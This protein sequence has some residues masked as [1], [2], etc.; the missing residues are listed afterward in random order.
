MNFDRLVEGIVQE[1]A[2]DAPSRPVLAKRRGGPKGSDY[3]AAMHTTAKAVEGGAE[4]GK[5]LFKTENVWRSLNNVLKNKKNDPASDI[6]F[7][8][9]VLNATDEIDEISRLEKD[10]QYEIPLPTPIT[11]DDM[12]GSNV[13]EYSSILAKVV[14]ERAPSILQNY[15]D[16]DNLTDKNKALKIKKEWD[17]I[18]NRH[19]KARHIYNIKQLQQFIVSQ[20]AFI[21][22][23]QGIDP[24]SI[25]ELQTGQKSKR[26]PWFYALGPYTRKDPKTGKET[27]YMYT[28]YGT[29][30]VKK[31]NVVEK[32]GV[33]VL[34][35]KFL[36]DEF[37]RYKTKDGRRY[38]PVKFVDGKPQFNPDG[39]PVLISLSDVQGQPEADVR[40]LLG[41]DEV[42]NVVDTTGHAAF[43]NPFKTTEERT[44]AS[45]QQADIRPRKLGMGKTQFE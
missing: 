18:R 21:K 30:N 1:M 39:S 41:V 40:K 12:E 15:K 16:L 32:D 26:K 33:D 13:E 6:E 34:P 37:Y 35:I 27:W 45:T 25:T 11:G 10:N 19:D 20:I 31:Y 29:G 38:M 9:D 24:A 36:N 43:A 4:Y 22:T 44:V 23:L 5:K 42:K 2:G 28:T 3:K 8:V 7:F 14:S 17:N